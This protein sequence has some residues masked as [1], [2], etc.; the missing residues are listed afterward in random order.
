VY[1]IPTKGRGRVIVLD[2][3]ERV[4]PTR[5][6]LR[7]YMTCFDMG[8]EMEGVRGRS[9]FRSGNTYVEVGYVIYHK[10]RPKQGREESSRYER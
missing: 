9:V 1:V 3:E 8:E 4:V 2:H 7:S 6:P 10:N 5:P